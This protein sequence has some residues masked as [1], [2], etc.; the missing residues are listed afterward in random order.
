M[1]DQLNQ[2]LLLD[3]ALPESLVLVSS[4]DWQ[5]QV[6]LEAPHDN[7]P[8]AGSSALMRLCV[9]VRRRAAPRAEAPGG[10]H[11]LHR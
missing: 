8:S 11:V 7:L 2:I 3:S 4:T 10:V 1:Y 9:A 5:G 6:S